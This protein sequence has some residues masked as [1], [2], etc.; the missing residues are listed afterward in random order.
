VSED[1]VS[2]VVRK[3]LSVL[4]MTNAEFARR[5]GVPRQYAHRFAWH[6]GVPL[7]WIRRVAAVLDI[8][9]LDLLPV[10]DG[11]GTDVDRT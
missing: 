1:S 4:G 11:D 7:R 5:L 6:R 3:R 2:R 9:P 10:G 8:N